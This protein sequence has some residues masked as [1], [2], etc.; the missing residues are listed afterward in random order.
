[1]RRKMQRNK[2]NEQK[3]K[4]LN[5]VFILK[6]EK[7]HI[8]THASEK[9]RAYS[10]IVRH[11]MK[12]EAKPLHKFNHLNEICAHLFAEYGA[13]MSGVCV[14][15]REREKE[16]SIVRWPLYLERERRTMQNIVRCTRCDV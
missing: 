16:L 10:N 4:A 15:V 8:H 13:W 3:Q 14:H 9:Q 6:Q 2:H 11:S 12:N 5:Y 1:M 7:T